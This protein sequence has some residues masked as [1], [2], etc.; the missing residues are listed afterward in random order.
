[1]AQRGQSAAHMGLHGARRDAEHLRGVIGIQVKEKAKS[2]KQA[3]VGRK[4]ETLCTEANPVL[5]QLL[6]QCASIYVEDTL[7]STKSAILRAP[8]L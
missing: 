3:A 4:R 5:I 2:R 6:V 7:P 1:M 8:H